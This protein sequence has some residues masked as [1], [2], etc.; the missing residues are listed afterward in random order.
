MFNYGALLQVAS[1]SELHFSGW[2]FVIDG[3][4]D[5]VL[6][7]VATPDFLSAEQAAL[8]EVNG[9]EIASYELVSAELIEALGL[10]AGELARFE[11]AC[12]GETIL[13]S[14]YHRR[15]WS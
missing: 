8:A 2:Q 10:K 13:S 6:I 3:G 1:M 12:S 5:R 11:T 15:S 9:G 14:G 4:P 7:L